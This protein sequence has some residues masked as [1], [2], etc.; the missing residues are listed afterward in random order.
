MR[1]ARGYLIL[2]LGLATAALSLAAA[3]SASGSVLPVAC[4]AGA[5]VAAIHSANASGAA[6]TL[7]LAADCT[8]PLRAVDNHTKGANGL[9]VITSAMTIVGNR[10][11][12]KRSSNPATPPFRLFFVD[13]AGDLTLQDLTIRNG[14]ARSGSPGLRGRD[15]V[16]CRGGAGAQGGGI[17]NRGTLTLT[18]S[19][20]R[21][22]SAGAG[23]HGSSFCVDRYCD[24]TEGCD[25]G[26]GGAGGGIFNRGVLTVTNSAVSDNASGRGGSGGSGYPG[27]HGADAGGGGGIFNAG[28]LRLVNTTLSHNEA[29]T[30]GT[31]GHDGKDGGIGGPGG[32][33]AN[34]GT[35][36]LVNSTVHDNMAGSAGYG[37]CGDGG[38][39]G[40]GGSG[41]GIANR[42]SLTIR[43]S[44]ITYNAV[45]LERPISDC[46]P[47]LP[48]V[49]GGIFNEGGAFTLANSIVDGQRT[50][51]DCSG[52][53]PSTRR[54]SLGGSSCGAD[55]ADPLLLTAAARLAPLGNYGG[56]TETRALLPGSD[57]IDRGDPAGC[58]DA[59]G[60]RLLKDQRGFPRRRQAQC[61]IGAIE[62]R[63]GEK[64]PD[65]IQCGSVLGPRG[66]FVLDRDLS[67]PYNADAP[68]EPALTV[69]TSA[70]LDLNG[71][72]VTCARERRLGIRI[73]GDGTALRNGTVRDC[74]IGVDIAGS[75]NVVQHMT[76]IG[77]EDGVAIE[78]GTA[79]RIESSVARDG[80]NGFAIATG[81]NSFT[82]NTATGNDIGFYLTGW[83]DPD[84]HVLSEN[85][86][87]GNGDGLFA[88]GVVVR[89]IRNRILGN[90]R[91]GVHLDESG[92]TL[93]GNLIANNEGNGLFFAY[94]PA[95]TSNSLTV[96]GNKVAD[97]GGDGLYLDIR[98]SDC[99]STVTDNRVLRNEHT[100]IHVFSDRYTLFPVTV[101]E[102]V[103]RGNQMDLADDAPNCAGG[104]WQGNT[105]QT[106]SQVCI[107]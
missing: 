33:I 90:E 6:N 59:E 68:S 94:C 96:T 31:G 75:E 73:E 47:G 4:D 103:A 78:R 2:I 104:V 100:G 43:S 51:E 45:G 70:A 87:T 93:E 50:G 10:A 91:D 107:H 35:V 62:F 13:T 29:G 18:N 97:N 17:F 46:D 99:I 60:Q 14:Q 44:T 11:V 21:G 56:P 84:P 28:T 79:N 48:G 92:G 95:Y 3:R 20:L 49:G 24:D 34:T 37:D 64:L 38:A 23:G 36:S 89:M 9:P 98:N 72:T 81:G 26:I 12:I 15:R 54:Y 57:A 42:G 105:F 63:L 67:C 55:E 25:G 65:A 85:E 22:N 39:M 83:G 41:G 27:G 77:N 101:T 102:N 88:E 80:T 86:A 30:G 1:Q 16:L 66:T 8:Y 52:N 69:V 74:G 61:D 7:V 40:P 82:S 32:G 106:A 58:L 53:L 71:Y 19:A 5:L 76:L